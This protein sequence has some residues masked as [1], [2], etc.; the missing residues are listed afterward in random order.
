MECLAAIPWY[1]YSI[2][3]VIIAVAYGM[4]IVHGIV[5]AKRAYDRVIDE[6]I[7]QRRNQRT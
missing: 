7:A 5:I 2:F 1:V 3:G 4:G 6:H